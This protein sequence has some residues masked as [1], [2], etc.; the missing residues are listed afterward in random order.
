V[1]ADG[2]YQGDVPL[3]RG[4]WTYQRDAE[5]Q[6]VTLGVRTVDTGGLVSGIASCQVATGEKPWTYGEVMPVAAPPDSEFEY[7]ASVA[8]LDG[9][10]QTGWVSAAK[11]VADAAYW[12]GYAPPGELCGVAVFIHADAPHTCWASFGLMPAGGWNDYGLG[13]VPRGAGGVK[14]LDQQDGIPAGVWHYWWFGG[15]PG[16]RVQHCPGGSYGV[17]LTWANFGG[18]QGSPPLSGLRA[19]LMEVRW[20]YRWK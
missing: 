19:N 4:S 2:V 7:G 15:A 6:T 14:I 16:A 10:F 5:F 9:N 11:G 3:G 13:D 20:L 1:F 17:R 12:Q 8:A 18:W